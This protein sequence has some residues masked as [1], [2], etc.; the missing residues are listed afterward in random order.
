MYRRFC[1]KNP[2][3]VGNLQ[4]DRHSVYIYF[5]IQSFLN[6]SSSKYLPMFKTLYLWLI[7]RLIILK[8]FNDSDVNDLCV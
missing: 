7:L 4:S 5:A 1:G 3:I 2:I 6:S 8:N